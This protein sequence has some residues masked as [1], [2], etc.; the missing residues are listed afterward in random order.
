MNL[1]NKIIGS[2]VLVG[3]LPLVI[4]GFLLVNKIFDITKENSFENNLYASDQVSSEINTYFI[5]IERFLKSI[6]SYSEIIEFNKEAA[7]WL[8]SSSK[9]NY[10]IYHGDKAFESDPFE[11]F[12][13]LDSSGK[14]QTVYPSE[15]KHIGMDYSKENSFKEVIG[16]EDTYFSSNIVDSEF[17]SQPVIRIAVP[18]L[19]ENGEISSV[20]VADVNIKSIG[21]MVA[22]TKI[23]KQG[24]VYV[25]DKEGTI[26]AHPNQ[27][28]VLDGQNIEDVNSG[29]S[30]EFKEDSSKKI[31]LYPKNDPDNLIAYSFSEM[32]GWTAIAQQS[33]EDVLAD[34]L[35]VK[36]Q[37]I[38]IISFIIIV[39]I[40]LALYFFWGI[41]RPLKKLTKWANKI[42]DNPGHEEEIEIKTGDEIEEL[43]S[44]FN[45]MIMRLGH[46][47]LELQER[48][49]ELEKKT[50]ELDG[51]RKELEKFYNLTVGRE[52]KMIELK[53]RVKKLEIEND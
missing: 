10:T 34:P 53:E 29:L 48:T 23:G 14:V 49:I 3:I 8:L 30:S 13:I 31:I 43:T 17:T 26:I 46:E 22:Q 27:K 39:L 33:L 35:S 25:I 16:T 6:A 2:F 7:D 20:L 38:I 42:G 12:L 24:Y 28:L 40:F 41:T 18:I 19:K 21:D 52:L 45:G 5:T 37:F 4:F 15:E 44:V 47:T 50:I 9:K 11:S 36:N 32:S 1:F 51:K